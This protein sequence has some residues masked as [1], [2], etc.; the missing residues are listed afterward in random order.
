MTEQSEKLSGH[1]ACGAVSWKAGT[2]MNWAV[3][4]HCADCR[5]VASADYVSWFGVNREDLIW[6][7]PRRFWNSS[8]GITRSFCGECGT[9]LSYENDARAEETDLYAATLDKPQLYQPAAHTFWSERTAWLEFSDTL[10]KHA[11]SLP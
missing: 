3:L 2:T 9:P 8:P 4:C 7:G 11:K 1:C 10:P 6:E 5:R